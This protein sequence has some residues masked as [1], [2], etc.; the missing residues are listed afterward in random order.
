MWC[1]CCSSCIPSNWTSRNG[2]NIQCEK[3]LVPV[4]APQ[5]SPCLASAC[6]LTISLLPVSPELTEESRSMG[7][8]QGTGPLHTLRFS[9]ASL[10]HPA[11]TSKRAPGSDHLLGSA[12]R[13]LRLDLHGGSHLVR[14][15]RRASALPTPFYRH[16]SAVLID[17]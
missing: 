17:T 9:H 11:D 7:S 12:R 16:Q 15:H 4:Q 14:G 2:P 1:G 10:E 3:H 6:H 8:P 13:L 5:P